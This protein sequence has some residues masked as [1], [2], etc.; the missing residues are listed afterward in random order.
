METIIYIVY[1]LLSFTFL[2]FAFSDYIMSHVVKLKGT[3]RPETANQIAM[4]SLINAISQIAASDSVGQAVIYVAMAVISFVVM[5]KTSKE[6]NT[7]A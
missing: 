3:I 6:K 5:V 2:G 7:D 1:A 4:G